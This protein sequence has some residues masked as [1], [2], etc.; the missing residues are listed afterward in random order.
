M[1]RLLTRLQEEGRVDEALIRM[2]LGWH[3]SAFSV[4]TEARVESQDVAGRRKMA[5]AILRPPFSQARTRIPREKPACPLTPP[6]PIAGET[7]W[8][9]AVVEFS[10]VLPDRG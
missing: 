1:I 10:E 4:Q 7:D 6:H 5:E 8:I 3:R 9:A 2:L